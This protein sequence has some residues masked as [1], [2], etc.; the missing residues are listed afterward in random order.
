MS[1]PIVF[2]LG[3]PTKPSELN[4]F[5]HKVEINYKTVKINAFCPKINIF[6]SKIIFNEIIWNLLSQNVSECVY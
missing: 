6:C 2:I 4:Y 5:I 1:F 3:N